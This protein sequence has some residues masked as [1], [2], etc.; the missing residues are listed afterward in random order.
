MRRAVAEEWSAEQVERRTARL[1]VSP[2]DPRRARLL[3]K[4]ALR[5]LD[6]IDK[7]SMPLF[8][9]TMLAEYAALRKVPKRTLGD[10][11]DADEQTLSGTHLPADPLVP[12]GYERKDTIASL[13]ML[14]GN[15]AFGFATLSAF[16]K[17]DRFLFK[18]RVAERRSAA[19]LD[20]HGDGAVGLPLLLGPSVD[21]RGAAAVGQPR[22][23]PQRRA[24]QPV[25]RA[26]PAVVRLPDLLGVR[27]D[28]AARLP[29]RQDRQGGPAQPAVPVLD[30]HRGHR[31]PARADREGVQHAVAPPRPPRRQ[32]AVP[33]QELRRDP[34][35]VGQAVR[36]VR[37]RAAAGEVRPDQ[38]HQHL[39]PAAHR[40]SR[41]GR[42][43]PRRSRAQPAL[44]RKLGHV[45]GRPGWTPAVR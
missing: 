30:P 39:Q 7:A 18:H 26:A 45:F 6:L 35:P 23:P 15:I 37:A 31:P 40:L 34:D 2:P 1:R 10:L 8:A 16:S 27:A 41:D 24:L 17:F 36:H 19:R 43:R 3:K 21:A 9:V 20:R 14:A 25:D 28:A 13:T 42:H 44:R 22:H 4:P 29:D 5:Q 33:R 12:L 38:E 11:Y 32:R